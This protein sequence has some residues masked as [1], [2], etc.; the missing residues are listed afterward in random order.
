[1]PEREGQ[2]S[3]GVFVESGVCH[4]EVRTWYEVPSNVVDML[5][6]TIDPD[7]TFVECL[8]RLLAER[9]G[10]YRQVVRENAKLKAR[11]AESVNGLDEL[12]FDAKI[13]LPEAQERFRRAEA[14]LREMEDDEVAVNRLGAPVDECDP[15]E[16]L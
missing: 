4:D 16:E 3:N 1:M 7:E 2:P 14:K 13:A 5:R 8:V 15:D 11:L 9:Q 12:V 6:E 10:T